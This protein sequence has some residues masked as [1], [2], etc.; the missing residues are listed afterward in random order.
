MNNTENSKSWQDNSDGWV[1]TMTESKEKKEEYQ[2]Y[3]K[4]VENPVSYRYWLRGKK[5]EK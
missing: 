1:K 4:T 5:N 2:R 3:L